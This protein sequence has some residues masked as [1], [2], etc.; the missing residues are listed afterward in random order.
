M[1]K[2]IASLALLAFIGCS[3]T[4]ADKEPTYYIEAASVSC[5]SAQKE[6]F[7]ESYFEHLED[8]NCAFEETYNILSIGCTVTKGKK[9]KNLTEKQK[10]DLL[11]DAGIP[12]SVEITFKEAMAECGRFIYV[13]GGAYLWMEVEG[14]GKAFY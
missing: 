1:K 9:Y 7:T 2:L 13:E 8:E 5:S 10:D 6:R 14:D 12:A 4:D 3:S 11:F